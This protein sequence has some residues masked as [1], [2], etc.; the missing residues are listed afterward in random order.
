[1]KQ[2]EI[3]SYG[4]LTD[5]QKQE[6][7]W[8]LIEGFGHLMTFS[9]KE[10]ELERIFL[11]GLH[12]DYTLA[13]VEENKVLGLV[14][15]A[16][17]RVRP[18]RFPLE[19]CIEL[20]GKGKGKMVSAQ[21]NAIFQSRVVKEDTDLYIDVL[22]TSKAARNKGIATKLLEYC[23]AL[24]GYQTYYIEVFSKN[25]VARRL[26]EKNG[27]TIYKKSFLSPLVLQGSGYPIKMKKVKGEKKTNA[28]YY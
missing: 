1:M 11:D 19:V 21:M 16:T 24:S 10:E 12:P 15:I 9:K 23:I 26:Y 18:V 3:I 6:L 7:V 4:N 8:I 20:F 28:Q 2:Y 5:V 27:F 14:G 13:Y 22:A 25:H 17:N